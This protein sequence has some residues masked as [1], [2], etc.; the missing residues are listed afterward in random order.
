MKHIGFVQGEASP[1]M[2]VHENRGIACIVHGDDFTSTGPKV[3]LDWLEAQFEGKF[4]LR[5]GDRLGPGPDNAT[6][7][8]VINRVLRYTPDCFEYEA[9]P[10]QA[11]KLLE[12][13]GLDDNCNKAATPGLKPLTEQ[14]VKNEGLPV[15]AIPSSEVWPP[16]RIIRQQ[17]ASTFS[18][19]PK[20]FVGL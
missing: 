15:R 8:T 19:L 13:L 2:F 12:G 17:I 6:E 5:K 14:L 7:L 18:S 4:G 3:G 10:R 1:C 20:R 16:G 11:E 9:D